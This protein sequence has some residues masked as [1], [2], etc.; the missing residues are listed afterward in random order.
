MSCDKFESQLY[1][2]KSTSNEDTKDI[3]KKFLLKEFMDKICQSCY[4][5]FN[6]LDLIDLISRKKKRNALPENGEQCIIFSFL[7][8]NYSKHN[9]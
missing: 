3:F 8:K 7:K 9:K 1:F 4:F 5:Q 6:W 2:A